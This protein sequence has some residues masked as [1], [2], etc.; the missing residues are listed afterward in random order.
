MAFFKSVAEFFQRLERFFLYVIIIFL[1]TLI[2]WPGWFSSDDGDGA[3]TDGKPPAT[4]KEIIDQ[5]RQHHER[6]SVQL[7]EMERQ[8]GEQFTKIDTELEQG[9]RRAEALQ[10]TVAAIQGRLVGIEPRVARAICDQLKPE[11]CS[12]GINRAP[13][14][15]LVESN[16]TLLFENARLD[17]NGVVSEQ[18]VGIRLT[19]AQQR[20]LDAIARAFRPCN[21]GGQ[22]RFSIHGSSSTAEFQAR[23][24][25]RE[26]P[27]PET[28]D[29]NLATARLRAQVVA[30]YLSERE[31]TAEPVEISPDLDAM[32]R[33]YV[34]DAVSGETDQEGLN[35]S[36]FIE[37]VSA[38]ACG[39]TTR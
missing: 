19:P 16:F 18:S 8:L 5:I 17:E 34:D 35:R 6:N 13:S 37:V 29:Y 38:G 27:L 39:Q 3:G 11:F 20:R 10:T 36:V 22:V 7:G 30:D 23:Q 25:E 2:A 26:E 24:A 31:F 21:D 15:L 12:R 33:P 4:P 28:D 1:I 14:A 32:A 9:R